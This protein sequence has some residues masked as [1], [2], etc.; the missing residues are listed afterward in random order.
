MMIEGRDA[1]PARG[2]KLEFQFQNKKSPHDRRTN[3]G[4]D[5]TVVVGLKLHFF[6]CDLL[7]VKSLYCDLVRVKLFGV[8][9]SDKCQSWLVFL[10][11]DFM[12]LAKLNLQDIDRTS[13]RF[14]ISAFRF[15]DFKIDFG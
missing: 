6:S 2:N 8:L 13:R 7:S 1:Q 4:A 10:E 3:H 5:S 9:W 14:K 12:H 11:E 15:K